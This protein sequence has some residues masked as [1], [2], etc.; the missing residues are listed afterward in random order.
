MNRPPGKANVFLR[1]TMW[2]VVVTLVYSASVITATLHTES[3]TSHGYKLLNRDAAEKEKQ[4]NV[5]C[6][7]RERCDLH[8][9]EYNKTHYLDNGLGLLLPCTTHCYQIDER[10]THFECKCLCPRFFEDA[11]TG[12]QQNRNASTRPRSL[13]GYTV[14]FFTVLA[15]IH[16]SQC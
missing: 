2:W 7:G 4:H 13:F 1:I 12:S 9:Y 14:L 6:T 8:R 5:S 15:F 3:D 16:R 10:G 11:K